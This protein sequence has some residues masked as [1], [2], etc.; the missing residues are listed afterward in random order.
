MSLKVSKGS[1]MNRGKLT[2]FLSY[3]PGAGKSYIMKQWGELEQQ[4]GKNVIV[5]FFNDM[6][7][8]QGLNKKSHKYSLS[9]IIEQNPDL[10]LLDEMGMG[11]L[12]KDWE[13]DNR[14][15][16]QEIK[17]NATKKNPAD[18][19]G[20]KKIITR[21]IYDDID[22]LLENG[23]DVYTT[24]NLK[25]FDSMN[26]RFKEISGIGIKTTIPD[27]YLELADRIVFVDRNLISLINDFESGKL[28]NE[29]Y[30]ASGIMKK[31]FKKK[32]LIDYRRLSLEILEEY[33]DKVEIVR[34][35]F[36]R[37]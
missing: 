35:D 25:R 4:K 26:G 32:T 34:N 14:K 13:N 24:A 22:E 16:N 18:S 12:N 23:I 27:R 28:F 36:S 9:N 29:K 7:R 37:R 2:I 6:H 1:D 5:A 21:H 19:L 31:N 20:K 8:G 10:V 30:M 15:P 3:T 11:G 17:T 33:K